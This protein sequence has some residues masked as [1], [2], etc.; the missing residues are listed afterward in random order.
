MCCPFVWGCERYRLWNLSPLQPSCPPPGSSESSHF[1][2][3][4]F[5][6]GRL[7]AASLSS[8]REKGRRLRPGKPPAA[9]PGHP[10]EA[11]VR[12]RGRGLLPF[13]AGPR[14]SS[15]KS[16]G[17]T[18]TTGGRFGLHWD[19]RQ[20][21]E[22]SAASGNSWSAGGAVR[23]G[24][25]PRGRSRPWRAVFLRA[26]FPAGVPQKVSDR[27]HGGADPADLAWSLG[28]IRE[29]KSL[30]FRVWTAHVRP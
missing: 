30:W 14:V 5:A 8:Q 9:P 26:E 20:R 3:V 21:S 29:P 22:L 11:A 4:P 16:A 19:T 24:G 1:T 28:M 23:V 7:S 15:G 6:P 2:V 27:A 18:S 25:N 13:P 10:P 12:P 17:S